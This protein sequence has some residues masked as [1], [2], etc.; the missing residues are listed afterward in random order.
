MTVGLVTWIQRYQGL[1]IDDKPDAAQLGS[2]FYET[3][4]GDWYVW[5]GT[6]WVQYFYPV[7]ERT[8]EQILLT[9]QGL[10]AQNMDRQVAVSTLIMTGQRAYY[11]LV[12][13]RKGDIVSN[14][15][16]VVTT[17]GETM[18]LSK[19]GLYTRAG[20]LLGASADQGTAWQ[21]MGL[22]TAALA[23]PVEVPATGAYYV[24]LLAN[25]GTLPTLMRSGLATHATVPIGSGATPY[26]I[27]SS[28]SDL[29]ATATI[30][31]T[32]PGVCSYWVG[33]S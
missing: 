6:E 32:T 30:S 12:P 7:L 16:L 24:A 4:T 27:E 31:H 28:L 26:G 1:S 9:T 25:G 21:S 23:S 3:D 11:M 14:V 5:D 2:T 13:L 20:A 22:K 17:A 19:A 29:P 33:L 10:V 18:S 15:H 8:P